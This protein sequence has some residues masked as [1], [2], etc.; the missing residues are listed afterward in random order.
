MDFGLIWRHVAASVIGTSHISAGSAC[1]DSCLVL[2]DEAQD[3]SPFLSIFISDGAGS[4][5][6]GG[7]GAEL[8]VEASA[9]LLAKLLELPKLEL[10]DEIAVQFVLA[11]R[12]RIYDHAAK[13]G[14]AAR[15]FACTYIGVLSSAQGTLIIQIG[16]GGVVVDGGQGLEVPIIPMSGEYAN[17]THFITDENAIDVLATKL[18][19]GKITKIAAFTDGIQRLALNMADNTAHPPFFANFFNVLSKST[20]SQE[21]QLHDALVGFL[22]SASV[23]ERTDD[24]KT[25]ALAVLVN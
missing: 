25:L 9:A 4:A 19:S 15:D 8:A 12:E 16:D 20:L 21:E 1:Q 7:E 18:Y 22:N 5:S 3:K 13:C 2:L 11:I 24:D 17:M 14:L 6:N 23:N 10:N